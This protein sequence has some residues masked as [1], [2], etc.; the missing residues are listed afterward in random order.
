MKRP[1]PEVLNKSLNDF[2]VCPRPFM[3][4][5]ICSNGDVVMCTHDA[6]RATRIDNIN[7]NFLKDIWNGSELY[8]FR[9]MLLTGN[10]HKNILCKNCEGY[11]LFPEEDKIDGFPLEKLPKGECHD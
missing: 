8:K 11:R 6:P 2:E 9:K 1:L 4:L 3:A 7:N 10:K 5:V